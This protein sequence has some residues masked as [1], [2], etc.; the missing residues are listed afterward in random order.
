M[1]RPLSLA[2]QNALRLIVVFIAFEIVAALAVEGGGCR[3]RCWEWHSAVA[4]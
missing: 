1:R 4:G 3:L 2:Q